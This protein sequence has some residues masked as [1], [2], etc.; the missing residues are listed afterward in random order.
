M[1]ARPRLPGGKRVERWDDSEANGHY[2]KWR[3]AD[4]P[5]DYVLLAGFIARRRGFLDIAIPPR[6][7]RGRY[8]RAG[9]VPTPKTFTLLGKSLD[10]APLPERV[11][12]QLGDLDFL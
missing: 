3:F 10:G 7:E 6:A 12:L 11:D 9:F 4:A 5:R 8:L 1:W 2:L